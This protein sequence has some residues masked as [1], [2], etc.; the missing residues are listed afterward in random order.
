MQANDWLDYFKEVATISKPLDL[1]LFARAEGFSM[2]QLLQ[3]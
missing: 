3:I 2:E 1:S